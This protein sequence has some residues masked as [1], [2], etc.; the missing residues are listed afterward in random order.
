MRAG[1]SSS[2]A[3]AGSFA[4]VLLQ[5]AAAGASTDVWVA[6]HVTH[7]TVVRRMDARGSGDAADRS[8][9]LRIV[10]L[11]RASLVEALV[12]P[13]PRAPRGLSG[14]PPP[15][16]PPADVARW[17][18]EAIHEP[19]APLASDP[20]F[21]GRGRDFRRPL[22]GLAF[23]PELRVGLETDRGMVVRR[24][25]RGPRVRRAGDG[26][27]GLGPA[28]AR[29]S[30]SPRRP[31][32]PR[33]GGPVAVFVAVGAGAYHLVRQRRRDA[34]LHEHQRRRVVRPLR[35]SASA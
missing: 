8:L 15:P 2:P 33:L 9:A 27:R 21:A 24:P 23:A 31:S 20:A 12:L 22:V 6:D 7:K 17:T 25:G 26:R 28:C 4:T 3:T 35:A 5:R 32:R 18:R 16:Q 1:S 34:A 14:L 10:E 11:M 30:R 29:S 19:V 13:P